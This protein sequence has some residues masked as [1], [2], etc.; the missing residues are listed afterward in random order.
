MTDTPSTPAGSGRSP[1]RVLVVDDHAA[2]RQSVADVLGCAGYAIATASSAVEALAKLRKQPV[3]V[4]V[5]DLQMPGM[6][7][8]DLVREVERLRMDVAVLLITAHA[9]I[10]TAVEAMRSGA[11]DYLEK[12]FDAGRLEDSVARAA[13]RRALRLAPVSPAT[14]ERSA[15]L[16]DSEAML[17]LREQVAL[18]GRTDETVLICGESG[19]GKELVARTLHALSRRNQGPFVGLNCPVLSEQLTESEL[20]GHTRGAFTGA[21]ADRVGRFE[22]ACGGSLLLD[23]VTEINPGLQAKLLRVLQER[24]FERVG[25]SQSIVADVRVLATTNRDLQQ[26]VANGR[27]RGDLYYRLAVVPLNVPPLRERGRDVLQ[28]AD[29]FAAEASARLE[30]PTPTFEPEAQSLLLSYRWPGNVRELHNVVTRACVL[31]GGGAISAAL[32][33]PW[34][35]GGESASIAQADTAAGSLA[36]AER[37]LIEETLRRFQGHRAKTAEALGIGVRTL[38]GKLRDYGYAPRAKPQGAAC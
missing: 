27:F 24:V 2:A 15:M 34:L 17:R 16:G 21:D 4:V 36:D 14:G 23:E 26:E 29:H 18:I 8:L 20:F 30:R 33:G 12:P 31:G 37:R 5:T 1:V 11:F 22:Q 19:V 28:L 10:S 9:S 32:I 3:D 6:T 38:S 13:Q 7:G 35:P 25:S